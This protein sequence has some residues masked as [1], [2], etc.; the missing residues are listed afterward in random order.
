M[1]RRF[2]NAGVDPH[3]Q[4]DDDVDDDVLGDFGGM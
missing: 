4:D 2:P 3:S 1:S